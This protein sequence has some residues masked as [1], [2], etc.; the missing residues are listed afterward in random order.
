MRNLNWQNE[1]FKTTVI[2][3]IIGANG[4][5]KYRQV[6]EQDLSEAILQSIIKLKA[7]IQCTGYDD[8]IV[9]ILHIYL[10]LF[11]VYALFVFELT[12]S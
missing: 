11:R 12:I 4:K 8:Y 1:T 3:W 6:K 10:F 5:E 9:A 7:S 2:P